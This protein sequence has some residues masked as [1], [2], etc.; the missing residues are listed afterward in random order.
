MAS[1]LKLKQILDERGVTMTWLSRKAEMAYNTV[2]AL[3]NNPKH[4]PTLSTLNR[5]AETLG[6]SVCDLL[7]EVENKEENEA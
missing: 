6:V 3:C 1:R 2:V 4:D 5:V 7:E